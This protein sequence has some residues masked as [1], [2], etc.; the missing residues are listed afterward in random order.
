MEVQWS[1]IWSFYEILK[2]AALQLLIRT[3]VSWLWC[4]WVYEWG[5]LCLCACVGG[6]GVLICILSYST[7]III[8]ILSTAIALT[9]PSVFIQAFSSTKKCLNNVMGTKNKLILFDNLWDTT[10]SLCAANLCRWVW[11]NFWWKVV[12]IPKIY[13]PFNQAQRIAISLINELLPLCIWD[14]VPSLSYSKHEINIYR[15]SKSNGW[16]NMII[17][18]QDELIWL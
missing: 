14:P 12:A 1:I 11:W 10:N 13:K 17:D 18:G 7:A 3:L 15:L 16:I 2:N 8:C 4:V 6:E 9:L 5:C